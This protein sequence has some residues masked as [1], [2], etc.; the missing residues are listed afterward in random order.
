MQTTV[1]S[2]VDYTLKKK[3]ESHYTKTLNSISD[4]P[5]SLS[6]QVMKRLSWT[7]AAVSHPVQVPALPVHSAHGGQLGKGLS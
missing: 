7:P 3:S 4:L 5:T 2:V 6:H 1:F